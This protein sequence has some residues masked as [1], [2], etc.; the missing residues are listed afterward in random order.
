MYEPEEQGKTLSAGSLIL[1]EARPFTIQGSLSGASRG[2]FLGS[3]F[4]PIVASIFLRFWVFW[5]SPG[6]PLRNKWALKCDPFLKRPL[7]APLG[8]LGRLFGFP[9]A[10]LGNPMSQICYKKQY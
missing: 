9:G 2:A 7:E 6:V 3:D 4:A 10:V 5:G 1:A 8:R